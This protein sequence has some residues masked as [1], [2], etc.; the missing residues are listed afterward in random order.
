MSKIAVIGVGYVGLTTAVG[1]AQLGHQVIG[2]D[3]DTKKI[4]KLKLAQSPIFEKDLDKFLSK[5]LQSSKLSFESDLV[6]VKECD[7]I[8]LCLP[9]PQ[10]EDGSADIS[11]VLEVSKELNN[12][13]REE[14]IIVIKS[15]VPIK[16]HEKIS[17]LITK[18]DCEVVSNPEFLR[19]GVALEDFLNPDRIVIGSKSKEVALKVAD[20]YKNIK[21]EIIF[22]DNTSAELIKYASNSYLA[23]RLSFVN[24]LAAY[25]E[26][27]GG[28]VIQVLD[29]MGKDKRIGNHFLKPG[30]G[31][32]GMCFP[33]DVSEL[34]TS[35]E[36]L[37]Q[38]IELLNAAL[39]SNAKA[40]LR[41]VE[42]VKRLLGNDLSNK[43]IATWGLSFKSNTDDTR[44]SPAISVIELLIKEK[45]KVSAFDPVV[46]NL[47]LKGFT[48]C[49]EIIQSVEDADVIILLTEW[50]YFQSIEPEMISKLVKNKN[51]ID[52]RNLLD[53]SKW[54]KSGFKYIGNGI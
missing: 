17:K 35:A 5:N 27:I 14:T 42:K 50:P 6:N 20:L 19:E 36:L 15:T 26:K 28:N 45:A 53:K 54:E 32:G 2:I 29:A 16:T 24:E 52:T 31:W 13:I 8:F 9:T 47:E 11:T 49:S 3:N 1:L 4:E 18:K 43:K 38:P 39:E 46:K 33:K 12:V 23:V 30:P 21:S 44:F 7:F 51:I 41:V 48:I 25:A 37:D 10:L 34:K 40:H 22:T